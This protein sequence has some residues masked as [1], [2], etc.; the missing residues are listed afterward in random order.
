MTSKDGNVLV[1]VGTS[2]TEE[3]IAED[4]ERIVQ[5]LHGAYLDLLDHMEEFQAQW[6]ESPTRAFVDAA[7][8]GVKAGGGDWVAS[9][10]DLFK[11]ETWKE[12]GSKVGDFAGKTYDR[13]AIYSAEQYAAL[14]ASFKHGEKLV[15]DAD[16]TLKNWAWW[17]TVIEDKAV[18]MGRYAERSIHTVVQTV[19][20]AKATV[21]DSVAKANKLYAHRQEIL[22]LP[23]LITEGDARGVQNFID[24]AL[25]DIDPELAKSIKESDEFHIALELIADHDSALNYMSYLSLMIEAVPPNFY[26]YVSVK[27]GVQLLL[28]VILSVV[29]AF[30]TVGAGIAARL[31]ALGARLLATSAKATSVVRRIKKAKEAIEA[32]VRVIE[33]FMDAA[34]DLHRLGRKLTGVRAR[35]VTLKGKTKETL[36]AKKQAIKR[37]HR[38]RLCGSSEHT[39]P[40]G[41]LGMV[42]YD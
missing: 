17:Q 25:V 7:Y 9:V 20:D 36:S 1:V 34:T 39:T 3:E 19:S 24:T 26:G 27:Y 31:T 12:V 8:E 33:D 40:R 13:A 28:E 18:D 42:V 21:I 6:D 30:F 10:G 23:N 15:D 38:C 2:Y 16:N 22:N 14:E 11:A 5:R 41:R 37:D 35:G 4:G 32:F 29:L